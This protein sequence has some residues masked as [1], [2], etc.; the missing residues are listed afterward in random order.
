MNK[1][2]Y[3]YDPI[4]TVINGGQFFDVQFKV[5]NKGSQTVSFRTYNEAK[6]F[7]NAIPLS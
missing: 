1:V 4:L 7:F 3:K 2:D 6:E 5:W